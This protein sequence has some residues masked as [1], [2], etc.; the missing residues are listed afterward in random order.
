MKVT[1]CGHAGLYV[2]AGAERILVDPILRTTPL[3]AGTIV[4]TLPRELDLGAMPAPTLLAITHAH[5]DHLDPASLA[6]LPRDLE[7]VVPDDPE[8]VHALG[9]LGFRR[10][11]RL[12]A[13]QTHE[14]RGVRMTATPTDS[15]ID[16]VG[17][18]FESEGARFWH[19]SDAEASPEFSAR[20][21][22]EHGPVDLASVKF[23]PQTRIQAQFLRQC[24]AAFDKREI[25]DWLETAAAARPRVAFPYAAGIC[26]TGDYA[27]LNRVL[28]PF[29]SVEMAGLL[30]RRLAAQGGRAC[31]VMPGD[32]FEITPAAVVRH[33]QAAG[34]IRHRPDLGGE[35]AWEPVD[36]STLLG[37]ADPAARA[38][39]AG[40]LEAL[41]RGRFA[42]W[43]ALM[44][45]TPGSYLQNHRRWGVVWQLVVHAGG[46][47]RLAYA[48]DFGAPRLKVLRGTHPD[49]NFFVHVAGR[50]LDAVL[51]G[52]AGP[53]LL[54]ACGDTRFFEKILRVEG[55]RFVV[56]E[57]Q[58]FALFE[59]LPDP[60]T[61]YLRW[62]AQ[63]PLPGDEQPAA[64][65]A[66]L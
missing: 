21:L 50:S 18:L 61:Y 57:L 10:L 41:L 16:E 12:A 7:V 44:M 46:G 40:R 23:Q 54:Y 5:I 60:L 65:A 6:M 31:A 24:G 15:G 11:T 35:P 38:L 58:G 22:A 45:A 27:W 20:I 39:L 52:T 49:A 56:P 30:D 48:I 29:T 63:Q 19:M 55:G 25:V 66:A 26:F 43:A 34:W 8:T 32:V 59:K 64:A 51:R 14:A 33:E 17:F 62:Y 53:E 28:Y 42:R 4:H 1:V 2:E 47:E 13:W 37:L 3:A 36:T 9:E